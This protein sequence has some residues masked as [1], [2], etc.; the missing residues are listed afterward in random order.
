MQGVPAGLK[1]IAGLR[2]CHRVGSAWFEIWVSPLSSRPQAP[3]ADQIA[4]F[5]KIAKPGDLYGA[6]KRA[7]RLIKQNNRFS[8]R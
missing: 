7:T 3:A 4:F 6:L 8:L 1:I 5:G 2:G